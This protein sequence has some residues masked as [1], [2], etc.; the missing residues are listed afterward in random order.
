VCIQNKNVVNNS[1]AYDIGVMPTVVSAQK[2]M[3][4]FF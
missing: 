2:G 4:G 3:A 1:V